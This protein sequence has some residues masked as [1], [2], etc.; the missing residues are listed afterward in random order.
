V[1]TRDF[2][3]ILKKPLNAEVQHLKNS[4]AMSIE[5]FM[6]KSTL[7]TYGKVRSQDSLLCTEIMS[8][9][10]GIHL[11]TPC[12]KSRNKKIIIQN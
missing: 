7:T 8:P 5:S 11:V 3:P 1:V 6:K 12:I 9:V 2:N 10:S 4:V